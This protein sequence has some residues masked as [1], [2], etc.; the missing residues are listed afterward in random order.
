MDGHFVLVFWGESVAYFDFPDCFFCL[1]GGE[2]E[3]LGLVGKKGKV[4]DA[5]E[6][7][8]GCDVVVGEVLCFECDAV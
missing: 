6:G 5:C 8:F 7:E 4:A 2:G 3:C 1:V